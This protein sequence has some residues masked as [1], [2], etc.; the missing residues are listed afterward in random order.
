MTWTPLTGLKG[1]RS[2]SPGRFAHRR[3]GTSGGCS[4]GRGNVLAVGNCMLLRCRLLGGARRFGAH[5]EEMGG[6]IP[7][8]PPAYSLHVHC[9]VIIVVSVSSQFTMS[10]LHQ[11]LVYTLNLNKNLCGRDGRTICGPQ[12]VPKST[13]VS[14]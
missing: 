8:W 9:S 3:V 4:G 14:L 11:R 7:W 1:Q 5:G 2:R 13:C 10:C 6:G 12:C